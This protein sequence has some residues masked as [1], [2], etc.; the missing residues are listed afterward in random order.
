MSATNFTTSTVAS[1]LQRKLSGGTDILSKPFKGLALPDPARKIREETER[2]ANKLEEAVL[3][4]ASVHWQFF[5]AGIFI[6]AAVVAG[7]VVGANVGD[8]GGRRLRGGRCYSFFLNP[9]LKGEELEKSIVNYLKAITSSHSLRK[10]T[11]YRLVLNVEFKE[12]QMNVEEV[13]RKAGLEGIAGAE[14]VEWGFIGGGGSIIHIF[15]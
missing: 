14:A 15:E 11:S 10:I 2:I 6:G 9:H 1:N 4:K 8:I 13:I 5:I 3:D 7:I 12:S